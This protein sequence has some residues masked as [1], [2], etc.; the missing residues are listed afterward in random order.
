MEKLTHKLRQRLEKVHVGSSLEKNNDMGAMTTEASAELV[1]HAVDEARQEGA[2]VKH[3][4][5]F[6]AHRF[7]DQW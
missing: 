7:L 4:A 2:Q 5:L 3:Q 1:S 6:T